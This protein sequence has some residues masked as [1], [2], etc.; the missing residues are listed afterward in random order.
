MVRA[1]WVPRPAGDV[2]YHADLGPRLRLGQPIA[3]PGE[4]QTTSRVQAWPLQGG[5]S[6][7][8]RRP[9]LRDGGHGTALGKSTKKWRRVEGWFRR[10]ERFRLNFGRCDQLDLAFSVVSCIPRASQMRG[11][12]VKQT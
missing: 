2:T 11:A 5:R 1:D 12:S 9:I 6:A 10:S 3:L 7:P 8:S 4:R